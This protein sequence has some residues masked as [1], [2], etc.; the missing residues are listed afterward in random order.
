MPSVRVPGLSRATTTSKHLEPSGVTNSTL[1]ISL[2]FP[3]TEAITAGMDT[4][5]SWPTRS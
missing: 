5:A 3:G 2:I 4:A 1:L